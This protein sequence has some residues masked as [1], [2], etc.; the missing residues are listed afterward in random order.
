MLAEDTL[1]QTLS[2]VRKGERC[3]RLTSGPEPD[4]APAWGLRMSS[5]SSRVLSPMFERAS[6]RVSSPL[7]PRPKCPHPSSA[8]P[9]ARVHPV[10][11]ATAG[12]RQDEGLQPVAHGKVRSWDGRFD[13]LGGRSYDLSTAPSRQNRSNDSRIA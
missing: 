6:V 7:P 8:S 12:R 9:L 3:W 2:V 4:G 13:R 5:R 11:A 1:T 10:V